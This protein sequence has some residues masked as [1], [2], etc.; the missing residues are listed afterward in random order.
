MDGIAGVTSGAKVADFG[1]EAILDGIVANND[2]P[3]HEHC[4][5]R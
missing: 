5:H 3:F 1:Q 4:L 2:D